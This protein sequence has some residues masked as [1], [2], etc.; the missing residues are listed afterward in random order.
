MP[1]NQDE[2]LPDDYLTEF[3]DKYNRYQTRYRQTPKESDTI[4]VRMVGQALS[5]HPPAKDLLDI[6]C[7]TGNLL[8][9]LRGEYPQLHMSGGDIAESAIQGCQRDASLAGIDFA[10]MDIREL[11]KNSFD[12][13]VA[14]AVAVYFDA[15]T[16]V[17][18][19]ATVASALRPGGIYLGFEWLHPYVQTLEI[20]ETSRSHPK[21][22]KIFFR[23]YSI[24]TTLAAEYGFKAPD[25]R[26]FHI[27]IELPRSRVYGDNN[28]GF[29]DLNSFTLDTKD[30]ERLLFRGALYQPW[31]HFMLVRNL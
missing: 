12:I 5:L 6:G 22:L 27:P 4:L 31:C 2:T 8:A 16:Y 9:L 1:V 11:P 19:I 26:P 15:E 7:S 28:D 30:G 21:G 10:V 29:Q 17:R 24:L 25:I 23:P 13:V 20:N 14:N 3:T 18:T